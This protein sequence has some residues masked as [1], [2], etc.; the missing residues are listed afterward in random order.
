MTG[1][2]VPWSER[3]LFEAGKRALMRL[4]VPRRRPGEPSSAA[5]GRVQFR[6]SSLLLFLGGFLDEA[7]RLVRAGDLVVLG[8]DQQVAAGRAAL[9][10]R[11]RPHGE[12]AGGVAR[13]GVEVAALAGALL[14]DVALLALRALGARQLLDLLRVLA[15]G[16]FGAGEERAEASALHHHRGAAGLADLAD[17]LFLR[18]VLRGLV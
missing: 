18:R 8:E 13:A 14:D 10:G 5:N 4:P 12:V 9:A 3:G 2:A 15:L 1:G 7:A 11:L 6:P 16:I 17:G